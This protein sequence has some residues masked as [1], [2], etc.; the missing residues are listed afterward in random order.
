MDPSPTSTDPLQ[1][2]L[3]LLPALVAVA[4]AAADAAVHALPETRLES[5][6]PSLDAARARAVRRFLAARHAVE[7]RWFSLRVFGVAASAALALGPLRE[8]TSSGWA[9]VLAAVLAFVAYSVPASAAR[10]LARSRAVELAPWL[11]WALRPL[12]LLALPVAW[13]LERLGRGIT[14]ASLA[15]PAP[16]SDE[17]TKTEVERVVRRGELDGTLEQ[18]QSELIRNVL[19]VHGRT[20]GDLMVPRQKV[21]AL[22]LELLGAELLRRVAAEQHSRFPVYRDRIDNVLGVLHVKDLI[23]HVAAKGAD[24]LDLPSLMRRPVLFVPETRPAL[25]VLNDMRA[26]RQHLAVIVDEFGGMAGIVT[27]EDLLEEI[28]G[29]IQD[30]HDEDEPAVRAQPDGSFLVSANISLADLGR[31]LGVDLEEGDYHSLGGYLVARA[32]RVPATGARLSGPGCEFVVRQADA[33]HIEL[34]EVALPER[35]SSG[36]G[37]AKPASS[38]P[39]ATHAAE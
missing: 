22:P 9:P 18:T 28:V 12:E 1:L 25:T 10:A 19:D 15:P 31:Q 36:D 35:S 21:S 24:A 29:E 4:F 14:N 37:E 3:A 26:G 34:V 8:L 30:E 38:R 20:V 6:A 7:T 17:L 32:G 27:L 39:S 5:L 33:R 23:A 2:G 13:P 11:I 16:G